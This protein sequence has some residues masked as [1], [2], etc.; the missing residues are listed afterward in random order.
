MSKASEWAS[1]SRDMVYRFPPVTRED[2]TEVE[3]FG[4][5]LVLK[6][7]E[8][9]LLSHVVLIDKAEA[10]KFARWMLDTFGEVP[11]EPKATAP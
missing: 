6:E 7:G 2:R 11:P 9:L 8:F 5:V 3:P 1:R 10:E 4:M